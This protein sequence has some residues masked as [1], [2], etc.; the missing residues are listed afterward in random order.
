V[1]NWKYTDSS[2][3]VVIRKLP[4]GGTESCLANVLPENSVI[5]PADS[6]ELPIVELPLAADE[7]K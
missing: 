7:D 2:N 5:E 6:S 4:N 3:R 1:S